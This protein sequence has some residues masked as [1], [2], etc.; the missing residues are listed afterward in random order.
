MLPTEEA[1]IIRKLEHL[2]DA[3]SIGRDDYLL[4]R[5]A[6]GARIGSHFTVD[7]SIDLG[8]PFQPMEGRQA[9]ANFVT[10]LSMPSDGVY[11]TV[12]DMSVTFDRRL[13]IATGRL[14][15]CV[16]SQSSGDEG[17]YRVRLFDIMLRQIDGDWLVQDLRVVN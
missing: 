10:S 8:R 1:L 2:A 4:A 9:L 7:A 6:H 15:A 16:S 17:V 12:F 13:L 3:V 11:V 5:A 14:S